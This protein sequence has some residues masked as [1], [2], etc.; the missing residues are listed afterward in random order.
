[1]NNQNIQ[2][3]S[4]GNDGAR[5]PHR[6]LK[7]MSYSEAPYLRIRNWL[8]IAFMLIAVIGVIVFFTAGHTP[9]YIIILVAVVIKI[10]ETILRFFR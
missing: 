1:M 5:R 8:N 7:R 4:A 3:S 2:D 10:I 6:H 9:G